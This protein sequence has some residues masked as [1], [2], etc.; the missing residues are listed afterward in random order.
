MVCTWPH[1]VF[2]GLSPA[3]SPQ[4]VADAARISLYPFV[5][6]QVPSVPTKG[7]KK[8]KQ[9]PERSN[10]QE[11]ESRFNIDPVRPG[12]YGIHRSSQQAGHSHPDNRSHELHIHLSL[13]D[14]LISCSKESLITLHHLSRRQ[15]TLGSLQA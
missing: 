5:V 15:S 6:H 13:L 3:M 14:N 1:S 10:Q 7:K 4:R 11:E 8:L 2:L 12:T 9:R